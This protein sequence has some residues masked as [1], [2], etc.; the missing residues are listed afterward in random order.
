M[1]ESLDALLR[2][3]QG[4]VETWMEGEDPAIFPAPS[5]FEEVQ[6]S[7]DARGRILAAV[8]VD[9]AFL[10]N[11]VQR[12]NITAP[13]YALSMIDRFA[14]ASGM[15]RSA[16]MVKAAINARNFSALFICACSSAKIF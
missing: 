16:Y 13:R 9:T 7:E 2:D 6:A 3:V 15:S 4:A 5:S 14:K 10:D 11:A 12:I 8:D 1:A